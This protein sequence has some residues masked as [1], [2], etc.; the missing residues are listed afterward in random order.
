MQGL[1]LYFRS[2]WAPHFSPSA[3]LWQFA[4]K[5]IKFATLCSWVSLQGTTW[6]CSSG[7]GL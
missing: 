5:A 2:I 7:R 4:H 1:S 3:L 6:A